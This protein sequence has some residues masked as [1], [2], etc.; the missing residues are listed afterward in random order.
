V[1]DG[2][3]EGEPYA[4]SR[5][6]PQPDMGMTGKVTGISSSEGNVTEIRKF[7]TG[8]KLLR[9]RASGGRDS[10]CSTQKTYDE[11]ETS[12]TSVM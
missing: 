3:S 10:G 9:E 2:I 4:E 11:I 12:S 5:Y 8:L 1:D 7:P 6:T